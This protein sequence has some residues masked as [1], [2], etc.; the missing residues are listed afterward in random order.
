MFDDHVMKLI[1]DYLRRWRD[2]ESEEGDLISD[3]EVMIE[4]FAIAHTTLTDVDA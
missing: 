4:T 1:Q 3:L 2:E